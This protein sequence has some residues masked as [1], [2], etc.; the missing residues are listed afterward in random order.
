MNVPLLDVV[1]LRKDMPAHGL[2]Q[3]DLGTVA[4]VYAPKFV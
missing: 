1:V 3:G 2:R 4:E